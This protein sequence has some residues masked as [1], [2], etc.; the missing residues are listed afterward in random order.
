LGLQFS[1]L[2]P[3]GNLPIIACCG[4]LATSNVQRIQDL[5]DE[6]K[7]ILICSGIHHIKLTGSGKLSLV[8]QQQ[9]QITTGNKPDQDR[10]I[11]AVSVKPQE[12]LILPLNHSS[13][14]QILFG[15]EL[16]PSESKHTS[17]LVLRT[18]D[19]LHLCPIKM[20]HST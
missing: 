12:N 14:A 10:V 16:I 3:C 20:Q 9:F 8:R 4:N 15:T 1:R 5:F 11:R 18:T 6:R 7:I 19:P 17:K 2:R 13:C